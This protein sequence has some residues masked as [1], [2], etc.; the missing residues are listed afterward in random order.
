MHL[1]PM[2]TS[3]TLKDFKLSLSVISPDTDASGSC[4][5]LQD[6]GKVRSS[7]SQVIKIELTGSP[8]ASQAHSLELMIAT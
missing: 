2:L 1:L 4:V 7:S 5:R 3:A 6:M 8:C